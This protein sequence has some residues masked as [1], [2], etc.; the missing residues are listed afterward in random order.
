MEKRDGYHKTDQ[1]KADDEI[2]DAGRG[3]GGLETKDQK[4]GEGGIFHR[5]CGGADGAS[6][7]IYQQAL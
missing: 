3:T 6:L 2:T 4:N 1:E 7:C 5:G